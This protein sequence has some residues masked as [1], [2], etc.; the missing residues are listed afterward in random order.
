MAN[1]TANWSSVIFDY[2]NNNRHKFDDHGNFDQTPNERDYW[3][4]I[5]GGK[6]GKTPKPKKPKY[7]GL[8][9]E[10]QGPDDIAQQQN[11]YALDDFEK[12][13][14][15][16]GEK[17]NSNWLLEQKLCLASILP[18]VGLEPTIEITNAYVSGTM[19]A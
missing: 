17:C 4:I 11:K 6:N 2:L 12:G 10:G 9:P 19:T 18:V 15:Y 1:P 13:I 7:S 3:P 5:L 8:Y 14:R 16:D